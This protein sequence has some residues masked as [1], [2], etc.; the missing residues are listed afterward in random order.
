MFQEAASVFMKHVKRIEESGIALKPKDTQRKPKTRE[1]APNP[2]R[3]WNL[4]LQERFNS[5]TNLEAERSCGHVWAGAFGTTSQPPS[6]A[7][8]IPRYQGGQVL[9][10]TLNT[11]FQH[12]TNT[13][14]HHHHTEE[15]VIIRKINRYLSQGTREPAKQKLSRF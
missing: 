11:D 5:S 10:W 8:G 14:L 4:S 2:L 9:P 7:P 12:P 15:F 6:S 3:T 1:R 13:L